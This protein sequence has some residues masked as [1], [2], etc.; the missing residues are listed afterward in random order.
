MK[1]IINAMII[2]AVEMGDAWKGYQVK[3]SS[4][5]PIVSP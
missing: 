5:P 2:V 1:C 3:V 4:P